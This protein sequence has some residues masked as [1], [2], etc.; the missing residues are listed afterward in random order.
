MLCGGPVVI[1]RSILF[2]LIK[3]SKKDTEGLTQ[4]IRASGIKKLPRMN[5]LNFWKIDFFPV[6]IKSL[7]LTDFF[8]TIFEILKNKS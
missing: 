1:I 3:S 6:E 5:E 7:C 4:N 8:P 2:D